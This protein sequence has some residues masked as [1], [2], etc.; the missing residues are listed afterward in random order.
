ML[1][2]VRLSFVLS[3]L[4]APYAGCVITHC[5]PDNILNVLFD[6][7]GKKPLI[8]T[9]IYRWSAWNCLSEKPMYTELQLKTL[10]KYSF[11]PF[12]SNTIILP[13]IHGWFFN[14]LGFRIDILYIH[15][16]IFT[17]SPK[18]QFSSCS[19]A[20]NTIIQASSEVFK[21]AWMR[22]L[23]TV[24]ENGN[25][26]INNSIAT[27]QTPFAEQDHTTESSRTATKWAL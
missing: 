11:C 5:K 12:Q 18:G 10:L 27:G 20:F 9:V 16:N 15:I 17:I 23:Q 25:L 22:S 7:E 21:P 19:G 26:N 2:G 13:L 8:F 4:L 6:Y 3:R 24:Q 1:H 14:S